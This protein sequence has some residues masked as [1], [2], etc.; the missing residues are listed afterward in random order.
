MERMDSLCCASMDTKD[1]K[2]LEAV[3]HALEGLDT[4]VQGRVL[5]WAAEKLELK[6]GVASKAPSAVGRDGASTLETFETVGEAVAASGA[7]TDANRALVVAAYLTKKSGNAELTSQY[8]NKELKHLGHG[9]G[10]INKAIDALKNRKPQL[11][12]QTKRTGTAQQA[13]KNFKVTA[14][15]FEEVTRMLQGPSAS[16]SGVGSD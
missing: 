16:D 5:R 2:A 9:I 4:D 13:R 12:V 15:G 3:L 1:L 7:N 10:S 14:A 11:V 6:P 8:V